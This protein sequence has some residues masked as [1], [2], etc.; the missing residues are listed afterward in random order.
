MGRDME[1]VDRHR[2]AANPASDP[3]C[4]AVLALMR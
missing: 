2:A 4:M 1:F 3:C